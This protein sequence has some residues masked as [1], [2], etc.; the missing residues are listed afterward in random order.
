M[1]HRFSSLFLA[2]ALAACDGGGP[3]QPTG[4]DTLPVAEEIALAGLDGPVEV[5]YDTRG[6]PHIYAT[7]RHD[8]AMAQGYLMAIDRFA[9]ME[10][11]RRSVLGRV[12]EAVGDSV[13]E[14]DLDARW[15]GYGR[16]GRRIYESL[17]PTDVT[18]LTAEAFVQGIN[19][20]IDEVRGCPLPTPGQPRRRCDP[21]VRGADA[22]NLVVV[23]PFFGH[24]DPADVFAM[25][26]FQSANLSFDA[27]PEVR[28][29]RNLAAA[30][31]AFPTTSP[32]PR[33]AARAGFFSDMFGEWPARAV[34]SRDGFNDGT[35][36]ALLPD[37]GSRRPRLP[38]IAWAPSVASLDGALPFLERQQAFGERF[39]GDVLTRGSN[40]WLVAGSL[41]ASGHPIM[42][43]DP[44]LSLIS[45]PVWWYVHLDTARANG[46]DMIDAEGIAFAGLPGVVLGFN[47]DIA[48]GATTTGYDVTDV[49]QEQL[50]GA[51]DADG[52]VTSG[53]VL[54]D[55]SQVPIA[56]HDEVV[57]LMGEVGGGTT[58]RIPYVPHHGAFIPRSC[59]PLP[60]GPPGQF[61]AL[62]VR[63]T[64][65]EVSN[66][67]AYFVGLLTAT[68]VEEARVAQDHFRVGSQNFIVADRSSILWSTES[69]IPVRDPRAMTYTID[70]TTGIPTGLCPH[71]VLPGTGEYEWTGDLDDRFVPHDVDPA[72]GWIATANQDNVGVTE[73]GNPCNDPHYLGANFDYGWRQF[74]ITE[75]LGELATR[76][77]IT[78][79]D[80][81]DLQG[82]TQSQLGRGLR[83]HIVAALENPTAA[84]PTLSP[85]DAD[86]VGMARLR[87]M[88]WSLETPTGVG[89]TDAQEISDSIATSIFNASITRIIPLAFADEMEAMGSGSA[90]TAGGARLLE[91]MM[92]DPGRTFTHDPA[93]GESVLW[94]DLRTMGTI[95]TEEEI[96][97]RG[98]L[99]GLDFLTMRFSP[100]PMTWRWGELHTLRMDGV[101]PPL[102]GN[103]DEIA[104]PP[105]TSTTYPN[106]Y[107][108]HGD[109][110]AVDAS[111]FGLWNTT[112]FSYGSGPSQRLVVEMTAEG[113]VAFNAL[114]GGQHIDPD[115][116][117]HDDE[118]MLWIR[119]EQPPL[120]FREDDVVSHH[121]RRIRLIL[122]TR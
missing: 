58:Y 63:Y 100:D 16:V 113:P 7:T 9:Q 104:L 117:H 50:T 109:Q 3:P 1:T 36:E 74:R 76:G 89:T 81:I 17:P 51:C 95:E 37:P 21:V 86:R 70:A 102:P 18:R 79:A 90:P 65:D 29:S 92:G 28:R 8:L 78:T 73:D 39:F 83:D 80:M 88:A 72:R 120:F 44:H 10:F 77:G 118:A 85:A 53:T 105:E 30:L 24:W 49:Y 116:P 22:F 82:E 31:A 68:T 52:N 42:S 64:G 111:N 115:S 75:R 47:R 106:G 97:V 6:V 55:G 107:P 69:R 34:F 67:L 60:A 56:F 71:M 108:R 98:V 87:L 122:P 114:P 48:W 96:V 66:E 4:I 59:A 12:A 119:N 57:H 101:P 62:T 11:I 84:V 20:Y 94:D 43:N 38:A 15:A 112:S 91:W 110:F 99:A 32:D 103:P 40:N 46:E 5:V 45:P 33:L 14:G 41:T 54:F 27:D 2:I 26:R 61:T 25:A 121:E 35:T 23:S 19:A 13:L 93:T